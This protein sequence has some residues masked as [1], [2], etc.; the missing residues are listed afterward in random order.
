MIIKLMA[1][2]S[3]LK[4]LVIWKKSPSRDVVNHKDGEIDNIELALDSNTRLGCRDYKT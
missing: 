1:N 4:K 2:N 3:L